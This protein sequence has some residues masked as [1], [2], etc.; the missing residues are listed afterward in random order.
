MDKGYI[1][2]TIQQI[3]DNEFSIPM[4]R[5]MIIYNDR[6]NFRC[7]ICH[8]GNDKHKKRGNLYF[9]RLFYICFRCGHK[10]TYEKFLKHFGQQIDMDKKLEMLEYLDTQIS[11]KDYTE[12]SSDISFDKL[13]NMD[14]ITTLFNTHETP[15]SDFKPI[16]KNSG[17]YQYLVGRGIPEQMHKNIYQAKFWKNA[18]ISEPIIVFLNRKD[19]KL[20]GIQIRNLK[21]AKSRRMF[22]VYNYQ[23]LRKWLYDDIEE[24]DME[25]LAIYNKLS[26]FFNILNV[27][28]ESTITVFEG[29][30]D[31]LFYPN[32]IGMVGTNSDVKFLE[33]NE[34]DLQY[35]FDNDQAGWDKSDEK[36]KAGYRT[37]LWKKLFDSIVDKKKS[38]DPYGLMRRISSVKDLNKLNEVVPGAYKKLELPEYFSNDIFDIKWIPKKVYYKKKTYVPH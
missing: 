9:N 16:V 30:L 35:F 3:I 22:K 25:E 37:F 36:I 21:M 17:F 23:A 12:N 27:S 6:I 24:I 28:F 13:L 33:M 8:E 5:K 15:I 26:Y 11:Y 1:I 10:T 2:S 7:P 34:V 38:D 29:Y 14:E 18:E 4:E 20:L 31:S 19:D 32:S